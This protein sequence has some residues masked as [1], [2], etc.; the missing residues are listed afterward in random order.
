MLQ[1]T[2]LV[3]LEKREITANVL[4]ALGEDEEKKQQFIADVVHPAFLGMFREFAGVEGSAIVESFT[5][6]YMVYYR[7]V[8]Q[9]SSSDNAKD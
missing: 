1:E 3:M 5:S 2:G 7:Y 8:L 9:K 6:G 4:K